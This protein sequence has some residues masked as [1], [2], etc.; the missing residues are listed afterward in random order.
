M[1]LRIRGNSVRV[2]LTKSEVSRLGDG[3]AVEQ[4]TQFSKGCCLKSSV[5]PSTGV[6]TPLVEFGDAGLTVFLPEQSVRRW[7]RSDDVSIEAHQRLEPGKEL[8]ILVEKD[9]ECIHSRM[10]G[11][12]DAFPNP[13]EQDAVAGQLRG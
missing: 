6:T 8:Q 9:F 12:T 5:M 3:N 4:T 11:N 10:E 7:A 2:R 13:R 1:K